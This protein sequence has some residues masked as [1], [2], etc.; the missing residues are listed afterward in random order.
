MMRCQ[1][2]GCNNNNNNQL[3]FSNQIYNKMLTVLLLTSCSNNSNSSI[4]NNISNNNCRLLSRN[5]INRRFNMNS[6]S[7][8]RYNCRRSRPSTKEF[9]CRIKISS[10]LLETNTKWW[11]AQC[12]HS[13]PRIPFQFSDKVHSPKWWVIPTASPWSKESQATAWQK[14]EREQTSMLAR[15]VISAI[16]LRHS[17]LKSAKWI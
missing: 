16:W 5:S 9:R 15:L 17:I 3:H 13:T 8:S 1:L 12:L 10:S 4:N 11:A 14:C 6:N 7:S 2:M